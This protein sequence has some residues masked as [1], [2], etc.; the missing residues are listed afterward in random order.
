MNK[1]C[2]LCLKEISD[3]KQ[4]QKY[5]LDCFKRNRKD[6]M[7]KWWQSKKTVRYNV[8]TLKKEVDDIVEIVTNKVLEKLKK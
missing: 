5:H 7:S 2:K 4:G 6:Y 8:D 1:I 3:W